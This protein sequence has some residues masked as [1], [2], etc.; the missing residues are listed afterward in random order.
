M[1]SFG[2][3]ARSLNRVPQAHPHGW[4]KVR[5]ACESYDEIGL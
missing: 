5:T 2:S 3:I 1:L 4:E